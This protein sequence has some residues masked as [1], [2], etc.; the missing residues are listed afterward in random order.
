MV[1]DAW[2]YM[3]MKQMEY[4]EHLQETLL[5]VVDYEREIVKN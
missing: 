2:Q 3:N 4:L 5:L 1:L